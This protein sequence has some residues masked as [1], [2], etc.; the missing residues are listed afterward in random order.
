MSDLAV[1]NLDKDSEQLDPQVGAVAIQSWCYTYD[2]VEL[3][4]TRGSDHVVCHG[5]LHTTIIRE[6]K[7]RNNGRPSRSLKEGQQLDVV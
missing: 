1:T 2:A 6:E 4:G 7:S 3:R 5:L